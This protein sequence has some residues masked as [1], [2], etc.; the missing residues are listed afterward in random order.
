MK[1]KTVI[2]VLS[3]IYCFYLVV[4]LAASRYQSPR[5]NPLNAE[6]FS[7]NGQFAKAIQIEP[8]KAEYHML[9]LLDLTEKYPKPDFAIVTL[10]R[11]QLNRAMEL[12]PYSKLY[13]KIY[14]K[15]VPFLGL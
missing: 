1:A 8:L 11:T 9:F 7:K 15:Y 14:Q 4:L 6:Y 10:M 3:I 12:K 13:R 2:P 5:L